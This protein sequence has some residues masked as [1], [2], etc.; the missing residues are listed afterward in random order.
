MRGHGLVTSPRS[1]GC[2]TH[3]APPRGR[4]AKRRDARHADV[5]DAE[6]SLRD[7]QRAYVQQV[8]ATSAT[9]GEAAKRLGINIATLWRKRKRWGLP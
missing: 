5:G 2:V 8:L 3:P 9:L 4:R 7:V 1:Q 6:G